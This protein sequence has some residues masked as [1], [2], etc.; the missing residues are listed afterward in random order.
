MH[1]STCLQLAFQLT[2]P[3]INFFKA[4]NDYW[5]KIVNNFFL[6]AKSMVR[7]PKEIFFIYL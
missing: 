4:L 2:P 7:I 1:G 3:K 6:S 5:I